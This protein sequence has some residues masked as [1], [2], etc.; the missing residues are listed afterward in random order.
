MLIPIL[1]TPVLA[2]ADKLSDA[3][4]EEEI[5]REGGHASAK[6]MLKDIENLQNQQRLLPRVQ[7][8]PKLTTPT[9]L[10]LELPDI[11]P[12]R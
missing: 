4:L 9:M 2:Q 7:S 12:P 3:E 6:P 10:P 11:V 1:G 5:V 8:A